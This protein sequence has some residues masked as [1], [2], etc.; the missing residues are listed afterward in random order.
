MKWG[1]YTLL[2]VLRQGSSDVVHEALDERRNRRVALLRPGP[3]MGGVDQAAIERFPSEARALALI[4][5]PH[6]VEILE[7]GHVHEVPYLALAHVQGPTL[8]S[9][10]ARDERP[11]PQD[12]YASAAALAS[13]LRQAVE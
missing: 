7:F 10:V 4:R 3:A 12:R 13:A 5:H 9:L 2:S 1:P 11:D 6:L 8:R